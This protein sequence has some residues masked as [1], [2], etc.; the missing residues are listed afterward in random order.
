MNN[1]TYTSYQPKAGSYSLLKKDINKQAADAGFSPEK[2]EELEMIVSEMTSNLLKYSQS[3]ELRMCIAE[4]KNKSYVEL[5]CI[6]SAPEVA[7]EAKKIISEDLS[8]STGQTGLDCIKKLADY[9]EFYKM[10]GWGSILICRIYKNSK[11]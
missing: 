9:F 3:G 8:P 6:D 2:L 1:T 5:I 11:F 10:I 7:D 4:I